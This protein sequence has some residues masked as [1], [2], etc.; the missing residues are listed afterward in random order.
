[1]H[2]VPEAVHTANGDPIAFG[3]LVALYGVMHWRYHRRV[4]VKTTEAHLDA[5]AALVRENTTGDEDD[6]EARM[7][8]IRDEYLDKHVTDPAERALIESM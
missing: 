4:V 7:F 5:I 3:W 6:Y 1:M 2:F 8:A